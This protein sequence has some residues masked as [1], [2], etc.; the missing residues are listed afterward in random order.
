MPNRVQWF[1][2]L[3]INED[4]DSQEERYSDYWRRRPFS[5]LLPA[6]NKPFLSNAAMDGFKF[7]A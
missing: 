3:V 7:N 1:L 5:I 6:D 2:W 4:V